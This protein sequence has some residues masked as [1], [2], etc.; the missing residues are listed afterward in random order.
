MAL[1]A[2]FFGGLL[3]V[4]ASESVIASPVRNEI[5]NGAS[6][7]K[8]SLLIILFLAFAFYFYFRSF[9][10]IRQFLASFLVLLLASVLFINLPI[11]IYQLPITIFFSFLFFFLLGIKD[12][13]FIR[14]EPLYYLLN[15]LLLLTI[16]VYFF[17]SNNFGQPFWFLVE[18]LAA[19]M[20]T[21]LLFKE[22]LNFV[23]PE[24]PSLRGGKKNLVVFG[25]A[26]IVS[27]FLWVIAFL[28]FRPINAASLALLIALILEDF[29]VHHLSGTIN[30]QIVLRNITMFLVLA[31]I[32]FGASK[33]SP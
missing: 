16:F 21:S 26:F 3:F 14:R 1:K 5:S 15:G 23:V 7:A 2:A 27:Q 17:S 18:S 12:L 32:I 19:F 28:P 22:F 29:I 11:T 13:I 20:A 9:F 10:N 25:L 24:S 33:W 30:R 6:V 4:I 31:M 8:Q